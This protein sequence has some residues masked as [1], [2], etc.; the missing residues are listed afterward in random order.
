MI[1]VCETQQSAE[2][3]YD[4]GAAADISPESTSKQ[5]IITSNAGELQMRPSKV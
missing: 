3:L 2:K 5:T 4:S 1:V